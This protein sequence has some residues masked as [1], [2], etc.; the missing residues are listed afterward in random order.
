[1]SPEKRHHREDNTSARL[2]GM[3]RDPPDDKQ[4]EGTEYAGLTQVKQEQ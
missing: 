2:S 3:R 4:A 1:M